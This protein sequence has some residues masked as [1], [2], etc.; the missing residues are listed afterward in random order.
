MRNQWGLQGQKPYESGEIDARIDA[1][2]HFKVFILKWTEITSTSLTDPENWYE[3]YL[4]EH[5]CNI[6]YSKSVSSV[7]TFIQTIPFTWNTLGP[8]ITLLC[9]RIRSLSRCH[10]LWDCFPDY[11]K[12]AHPSL[13]PCNLS[14]FFAHN[15][16]L[17]DIISCLILFVSSKDHW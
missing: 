2:S 10:L 12:I 7:R 5:I 17:P 6:I 14:F 11:T 4:F 15:S 1:S 13:Y 8:D 3:Y 9:L 16:S